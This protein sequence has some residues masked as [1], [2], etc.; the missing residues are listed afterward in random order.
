MIWNTLTSEQVIDVLLVEDDSDSASRLDDLFH[1]APFPNALHVVS[2]GE[3]ALEVVHQRGE[4][5]DTPTPDLILLNWHLP[6][7]SGE[8][9]LEELKTNSWLRHIPVIVLIDFEAGHD[10]TRLYENRANACIRKP[11]DPDAF[12]ERF[13]SV[14]KFWLSA[15]HLPPSTNKA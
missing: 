15:V 8:E 9:V 3:E 13:Q 10:V 4:H 2:D 12:D 14:M 11:D 7:T 1:D 5:L 6:T